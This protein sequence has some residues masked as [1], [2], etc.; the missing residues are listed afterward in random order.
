MITVKQIGNME[1][2]KIVPKDYIFDKN[3]SSGAKGILTILYTL[4]NNWKCSS[5]GL[6]GLVKDGDDSVKSKLQELEDNG[7]LLRKLIRNEDGTLNGYEYIIYPKSTVR[8]KTTN[9]KAPNIIDNINNNNKYIEYSN[10][11]SSNN[12]ITNKDTN[13]KRN[14]ISYKNNKVY[15]KENKDDKGENQIDRDFEQFWNLYPNTKRKVDKK[16]CLTAWN[17]IE[18]IDIE[19]EQI[20]T[21]LQL[22]LNSKDWKKEN[23]QFIPAPLAFLHKE[24]W[25]S[26]IKEKIDEEKE[27]N[28]FLN[29][30]WEV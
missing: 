13:I 4:P 6:T 18:N 29:S 1:E 19:G 9:G 16:R 8:G 10:V 15:I 20:I 14:N 26:I 5:L 7:Y 27:V 24:Y 17:N 30:E 2:F 12:N 22:W 25:K 11:Y 23:G 21:G 28:D 3:L